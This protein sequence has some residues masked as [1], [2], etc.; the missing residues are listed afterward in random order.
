MK[1]NIID[2]VTYNYFLN[3]VLINFLSIIYSRLSVTVMFLDFLSSLSLLS[4]LLLCFVFNTTVSEKLSYS[5][6][7]WIS[8]FLWYLNV[9]FL[10]VGWCGNSAEWSVALLSVVVLLVYRYPLWP[11]VFNRVLRSQLVC[12]SPLMIST[13]LNAS[14]GPL[15][16][17]P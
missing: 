13:E 1:V 6:V 16:Y 4:L 12:V 10:T 8:I 14:P 11:N 3:H 9:I 7:V 15:R 2:C 5:Y 17:A